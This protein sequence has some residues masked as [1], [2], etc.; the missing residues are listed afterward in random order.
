MRVIRFLWETA[1]R[2]AF[3]WRKNE[4]FRERSRGT[5]LLDIVYPVFYYND[6]LQPSFS[7]FYDFVNA[8]ANSTQ[9]DRNILATR[10][11]RYANPLIRDPISSLYLY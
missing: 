8:V 9:S 4:V 1:A 7:I 10:V 11:F 5:S 3:D 6:I 2:A